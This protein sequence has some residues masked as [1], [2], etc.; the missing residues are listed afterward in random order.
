[1][2]VIQ[3][4]LFGICDRTLRLRDKISV[5]PGQFTRIRTGTGTMMAPPVAR[6]AARSKNGF[7]VQE[8]VAETISAT[9]SFW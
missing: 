4:A 7:T 5:T 1:L 2:K 3:S 6:S 8:A 9:V